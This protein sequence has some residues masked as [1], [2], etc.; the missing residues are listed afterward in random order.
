M[1]S[2]TLLLSTNPIRLFSIIII[3]M[4][5]LSAII[6]TM[7]GHLDWF[8][9]KTP[10]NLM[11]LSVLLGINFPLNSIKKL[12]V[13]FLFFSFGIAIEWVGVHYDFVFGSYSY[14]QN[15]GTKIDGVPLLIGINWAMLI[16]ICGAISD[17][18]A[19]SFV[20]KIILGA[21]FMVLLDFFIEVPAPQLGF[22]VF[23]GGT[24]P[25]RNYLAWFLISAALLSV[26]HKQKIKGDFIFS[27]HLYAAQLVFFAFFYVRN[28][29]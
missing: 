1:K 13:S 19:N 3:W 20:V 11:I 2:S 12:L 8:I 7:L 26:Y 29:L 28:S 4:F 21:A 14:A 22:W 27:C 15:L 24:A 16:L 6:G 25:L 10:L 17:K 5:H 9:V 18:L 23:E